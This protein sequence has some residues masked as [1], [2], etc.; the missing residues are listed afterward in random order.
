MSKAGEAAKARLGEMLL[1]T[2]FACIHLSDV[3]GHFHG[4]AMGGIF[5][6]AN[7]VRQEQPYDPKTPLPEATK[8]QERCIARIS[9]TVFGLH[10]V[11]Y[12][13]G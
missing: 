13:H 3:G 4:A 7:H 12:R 2:I 6:E 8:Q 5:E 9:N 1:G 10:R 11:L